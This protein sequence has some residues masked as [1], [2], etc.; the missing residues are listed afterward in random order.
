MRSIVSL[1][2][3]MTRFRVWQTRCDTSSTSSMVLTVLSVALSSSSTH[4]HHILGALL[5]PRLHV[6]PLVPGDLNYSY[7]DHGY[8]THSYLD[9]GYLAL[10][11]GN[12]NKAQR[13]IIGMSP[14]CLLLQSQCSQ[15]DGVPPAG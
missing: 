8:P 5:C 10:A 4:L 2:L 12:L 13:T 7:L 15:H 14:C 3:S 11:L 1:C 9:H 6:R